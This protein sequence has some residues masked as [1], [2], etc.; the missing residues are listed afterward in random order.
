LQSYS[1]FIIK[2]C[3]G[4]CLQAMIIIPKTRKRI[5]HSIIFQA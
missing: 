2:Y 3:S 5:S 4:Y 1:S